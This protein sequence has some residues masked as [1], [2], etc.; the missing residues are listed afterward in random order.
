MHY[1]LCN[2]YNNNSNKFKLIKKLLFYN[3]MNFFYFITFNI[4]IKIKKIVKLDH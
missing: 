4:F 1:I 2:T 3:L